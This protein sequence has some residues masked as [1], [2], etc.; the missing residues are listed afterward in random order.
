MEL[1]HCCGLS[2]NRENINN[3]KSISNLVFMKAIFSDTRFWLLGLAQQ[4]VPTVAVLYRRGGRHQVHH[5]EAVPKFET[6]WIR[7][8]RNSLVSCLIAVTFISFSINYYLHS[9]H[10]FC[11]FLFYFLVRFGL[12][13]EQLA[14]VFFLIYCWLVVGVVYGC[15]KYP[16]YK[17]SIK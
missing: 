7:S 15:Y 5:S 3:K 12:C 9:H 16:N 2:I 13:L 11:C 14:C 10:P 1:N 17:Y 8:P 4:D 6:D